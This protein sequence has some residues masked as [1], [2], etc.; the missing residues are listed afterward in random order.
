MDLY[1]LMEYVGER[2]KMPKYFTCV[3]CRKFIDQPEL[4]GYPHPVWFVDQPYHR[5]CAIRCE[6]CGE[7]VPQVEANGPNGKF[8]CYQCRADRFR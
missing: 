4:D 8:R 5:E 2:M 1:T 3:E 6:R 7:V